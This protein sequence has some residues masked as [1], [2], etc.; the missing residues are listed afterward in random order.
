MAIVFS[1]RVFF[2]VSLIFWIVMMT[3]FLR[4]HYRE[5]QAGETGAILEIIRSTPSATSW[6]GIYQAERKIGFCEVTLAADVLGDAVAYRIDIYVTLALPEKVLAQGEV[7]LLDP[8][9]LTDFS[10]QT[11]F[12]TRMLY[13]NGHREENDLVIEHDFRGFT[14]PLGSHLDDL[15]SVSVK[16]VRIP[17]GQLPDLAPGLSVGE[18]VIKIKGVFTP[19]RRYVISSAHHTVSLCIDMEG[20]VVRMEFPGRLSVVWEPKTLAIRI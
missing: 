9:G 2:L 18:E 14:P 3:L 15:V 12:G 11:R 4:A 13:V 6:Y 19:V 1:R 7:T 8:G 17:L 20:T 10:F 5:G 16:R